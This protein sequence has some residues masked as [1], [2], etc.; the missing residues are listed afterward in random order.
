MV[1]SNSIPTWF[2]SDV[3]LTLQENVDARAEE[4][5][6]DAADVHRRCEHDG[7]GHHH[8]ADEH[9]KGRCDL[10]AVMDC[11]GA[12][13]HGDRLRICTSRPL[14]SASWRHVGIR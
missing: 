4:D 2:A 8:A 11:N 6:S 3:T 1:A 13:L 7:F 5:E 9:G 14:Q 12:R 10:P